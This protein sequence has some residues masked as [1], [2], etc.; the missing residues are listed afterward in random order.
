MNPSSSSSSPPKSRNVPIVA[1]DAEVPAGEDLQAA[2]RMPA[3]LG[4][5][6]ARILGAVNR[7][8]VRQLPPGPPS[9]YGAKLP[10]ASLTRSDAWMGV[11][12]TFWLMRSNDSVWRS[13]ELEARA[14]ADGAHM[15]TEEAHGIGVHVDVLL[16]PREARAQPKPCAETGS[17]SQQRAEGDDSDQDV[18]QRRRARGWHGGTPP[19]TRSRQPPEGLQRLSALYRYEARGTSPGLTDARDRS[20]VV[21]RVS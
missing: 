3:E 11:S 9:K 14:A 5:A 13:K 17:G 15:K 21:H 16:D 2:T 4:V 7:S 12:I 20:G 6:L 18:P 1:V 10:W 8:T 19:L